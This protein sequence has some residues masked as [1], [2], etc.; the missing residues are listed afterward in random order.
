MPAQRAAALND[1]G[2]GKLRRPRVPPTL[3]TVALGLAGLGQAWHATEPVLGVP[4][5][6]ASWILAG[7]RST[8]A[9]PTAMTAP[10]TGPTR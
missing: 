5:A 3:F 4:A 9:T 1:A 7:P 6:V 8:Y 2:H 10:V